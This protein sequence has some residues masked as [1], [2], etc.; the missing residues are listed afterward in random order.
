MTVPVDESLHWFI[1]SLANKIERAYPNNC[2][3]ADDYIQSGYLKLTEMQLLGNINCDNKGY[4]IVSIS[5]AMRETAIRATCAVYA[6]VKIKRMAR[7]AN[8]M[9]GNMCDEHEVCDELGISSKKLM[10]LRQLMNH[11]SY[12]DT[13]DDSWSIA[14]E[15]IFLSDIMDTDKL[16]TEEK[17]LIQSKLSGENPLLDMTRQQK[18]VMLKKIRKI[19]SGD[20]C[21]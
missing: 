13:F 17:N 21:G 9:L 19:I 1:I 18:H 15:L 8:A 16:T 4:A 3:C 2:A 6:P 14:D 11:Y 7:R 10:V 20:F 12:D 5:R